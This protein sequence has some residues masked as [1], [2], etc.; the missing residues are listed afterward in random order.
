MNTLYENLP[1]IDREVVKVEGSKKRVSTGTSEENRVRGRE[2]VEASL[3]SAGVNSCSEKVVEP[4]EKYLVEKISDSQADA[5]S[6]RANPGVMQKGVR[7]PHYTR[8][9]VFSDKLVLQAAC[10]LPL[11][12]IAASMDGNPVSGRVLLCNHSEESGGKLVYE[13]QKTGTEVILDLKRGESNRAQRL[14][15]K[16]M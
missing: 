15:F 1:A 6:K 14:I 12:I 5:S 10:C 13:F 2:D 3:R 11:K 9:L 8:M 4:T 16:G 7:K